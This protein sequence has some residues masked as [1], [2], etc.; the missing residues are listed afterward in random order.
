MAN[1]VH[2]M[3]AHMET[4]VK[5]YRASESSA[6]DMIGTL[7]SIFDDQVDMTGKIVYNTADLLDNNDKRLELLNTW[8]RQQGQ[9]LQSV[10]SFPSLV[11]TAPVSHTTNGS[12]KRPSPATRQ[13]ITR[14]TKQSSSAVWARVEEAAAN[15]NVGA[16][17]GL[18][19]RAPAGGKVQSKDKF[20]ALPG[21][22]H[23]V[24]ASAV[25][26]ATPWASTRSQATSPGSTYFPVA[27][28]GLSQA[29]SSPAR[30]PAARTPVASGSRTPVAD[31]PSLPLAAQAKLRAAQKATLF[32]SKQQ[33]SN[34]P[35]P[36]GAPSP[37][38]SSAQAEDM[39]MQR[40]LQESLQDLKVNG[41]GQADMGGR[42]KK[43][44]KQVLLHYGL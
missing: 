5:S 16:V 32:P 43:K 22:Q 6:E 30:T 20:P 34:A 12:V 44:G 24:S 26:G 28:A 11:P 17:P 2:R 25:R 35:K 8:D 1:C 36:W 38:L 42:K 7:Y 40:A 21:S 13:A 33:D 18:T 15:K 4:T 41:D 27:S 23:A 31:F 9:L 39:Q 3:I 29:L 10:D 37:P 19:Q 14:S